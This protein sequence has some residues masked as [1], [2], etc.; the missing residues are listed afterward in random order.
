M[1]SSYDA[2]LF[3]FLRCMII[4]NNQHRRKKM[5]LFIEDS[6]GSIK[7]LEVN[8]SS[9]QLES[10]LAPLTEEYPENYIIV[11]TK[12]FENVK[13]FLGNQFYFKTQE[14]HIIPELNTNYMHIPEKLYGI[15]YIQNIL[16]MIESK[17]LK[18]RTYTAV[19]FQFSPAYGK[20][21]AYPISSEGMF[22]LF[23]QEN[24][25]CA[26][27]SFQSDLLDFYFLNDEELKAILKFD[28]ISER[29]LPKKC[30]RVTIELKPQPVNETTIKSMLSFNKM[31]EIDS[32]LLSFK[33]DF[34]FLAKQKNGNVGMLVTN[35]V[36]KND[37]SLITKVNASL[38][39]RNKMDADCIKSIEEVNFGD[40]IEKHK[41]AKFLVRF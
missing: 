30:P 15:K 5:R 6:S 7:Q 29:E 8:L 28:Y 34:Y 40:Y 17:F 25:N 16:K 37:R 27:S 4:I 39:S 36:F 21:R 2:R 1:T 26:Y 22:G 13:S 20:Y 11:K 38:L 31:T 3:Q 33:K 23:Y 19:T 24:G 18:K 10:M 9:K 14:S 12:N 41:F 35:E 32:D